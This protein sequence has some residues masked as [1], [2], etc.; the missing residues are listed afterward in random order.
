MVHDPGHHLDG[1]AALTMGVGA[2]T[3]LVGNVVYLWRLG[4]GGRRW[5]VV[6]ARAV[7]SRPP[8]S[9]TSVS[10]PAQLAALVVVLLAASVPALRNRPRASA[11][12]ARRWVRR[13]TTSG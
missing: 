7:A 1:R 13:S 8:R 9:G 4:I 10:G 11:H 12:A 5:L 3:Y 6:T 2:S